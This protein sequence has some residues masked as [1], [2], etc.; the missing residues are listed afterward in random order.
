MPGQNRTQTSAYSHR[1]EKARWGHYEKSH[2][3]AGA[4]FAFRSFRRSTEFATR[5]G[6]GPFMGVCCSRKLSA[7]GR[8]PRTKAYSGQPHVVY[9]CTNRRSFYYTELGFRGEGVATLDHRTWHP[10]N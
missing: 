3:D 9:A 7:S 8:G 6:Q 10:G 2:L 4:R 1:H 5:I